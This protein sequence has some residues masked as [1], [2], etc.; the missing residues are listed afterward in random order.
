MTPK[1]LFPSAK[2]KENEWLVPFRDGMAS[3]Y[4]GHDD[5]GDH[6]ECGPQIFCCR[7]AAR[8]LLTTYPE[9]I[10]SDAEWEFTD[11]RN[12]L[13]WTSPNLFYFFFCDI[14]DRNSIFFTGVE[15]PDIQDVLLR[16]VSLHD[17]EDV[18]DRISATG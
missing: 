14:E 10:A 18:A 4:H 5:D 16:K 9:G 17:W 13:T 7:N 1:L 8:V 2:Q 11:D 3:F 6:S 15:R 12:L